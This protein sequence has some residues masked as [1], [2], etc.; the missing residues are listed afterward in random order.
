MLL[1]VVQRKQT[2][3][4][5]L[6]A[7]E[8]LLSS[9]AEIS[10]VED[11]IMRMTKAYQFTKTDVFCITSNIMVTVQTDEGDIFTQIRRITERVTNMSIIESVNALSRSISKKPLLPCELEESIKN[12]CKK[13]ETAKS[14]TIAAHILIA[15]ALAVFFGGS[16]WDGFAAAFCSMILYGVNYIGAYLKIQPIVLILL[17]SAAMCFGAFV[18]VSW[19]IGESVDK[20]IIGNIMLLIPG[21]YLVSALRDMIAG[22]IMSGILGICDALLRAVAIAAGCALVIMQLGGAA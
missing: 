3:K 6:D 5:I 14:K 16:I 12:I 7:G 17:S 1:E 10:R 20:I 13:K 18:V 8:L 11:T 22:D 9:G 2:L 19:G 21:V 15:G 4:L